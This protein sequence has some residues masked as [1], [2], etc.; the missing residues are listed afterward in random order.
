MTRKTHVFVSGCYDILHAGHIQFFREARALGD[1]LTVCFASSD[2][3]WAHKRRCSSLPDEHKRAILSSLSMVDRVVMGEDP[4]PGLDFEG[5]FLR[6]RPDILAVTVDDQYADAKSE[7]C[8][9]VGAKYHV[10]DKSPPAVAPV[11]TTELVS[12]IRAPGEAPLRVDFAGGWLDVPRFARPGG[13]IV[14]CAISPLVSLQIWPYRAQSGL[15]GSGAY[16]MLRGDDGVRAELEL[17]VGWQDPAIIAE[18]GLCVWKSGGEPRLEFKRDGEMLRG[19][20]G[21]HWTGSPHNTPAVADLWR[22]L[23]VIQQAGNLARE[24]VFREDL[25]GL[26][27][28]IRLSH[29]AQI[30]EGMPPLREAANA[31]ACK[32]CGGGWGGYAL[33]L[34]ATKAERDE[35]ARSD[36]A[37]AIEPY[38]RQLS[39]HNVQGRLRSRETLEVT[40]LTA[41]VDNAMPNRATRGAA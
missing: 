6:L 30:E 17:G 26:A 23:D 2:V 18:T 38:L 12:H 24:A 37:M 11:S 16:A 9:R 28:A 25:E 29:R 4:K 40:P 3:L 34:F 27:E 21:L 22:D 5:H 15:G 39:K 7:L 33:H 19:R 13:Y 41:A 20:M 36:G 8:T 31:L 35:W 1:E 10:L 32:Y 14:N